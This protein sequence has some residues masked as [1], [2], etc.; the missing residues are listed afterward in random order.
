MRMSQGNDGWGAFS[1]DWAQ[2]VI[3]KLES[4]EERQGRLEDTSSALRVEIARLNILVELW[5][6]LERRVDHIETRL[7]SV[8]GDSSRAKGIAAALGAVAG[9][10]VT[11][12][13]RWWVP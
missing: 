3:A 13:S 5:P 9:L 1:R 10:L 11:L 12:I 7:R 6:K 4:L 2:L 8:E